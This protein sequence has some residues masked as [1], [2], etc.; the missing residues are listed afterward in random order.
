MNMSVNW[1]DASKRILRILRWILSSTGPS[2]FY[3]HDVFF[4]IK[5]IFLIDPMSLV[6]FINSALISFG[7]YAVLVT[8]SPLF[9]SDYAMRTKSHW[10][11]ILTLIG[12]SVYWKNPFEVA[13]SL[14]LLKS[15]EKRDCNRWIL[16][17][18]HWVSQQ[19]HQNCA[20]SVARIQMRE[21]NNLW[22]LE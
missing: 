14:K 11:R 19:V 12:H 10:R 13:S 20:E 1:S 9:V 17:G 6:Q 5:P 18:L 21:H 2:N 22:L 7:P 16:I 15:S 3:Q 8:A 4:E